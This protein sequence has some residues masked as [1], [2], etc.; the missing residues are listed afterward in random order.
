MKVN[1]SKTHKVTISFSKSIDFPPVTANG[2]PIE[3]VQCAKLVGVYI[4]SILNGTHISIAYSKKPNRDSFFYPNYGEHVLHQRICL[5]STSALSGQ[6]WSMPHPHG[7]HR[8]RNTYHTNS[9]PYR[10]EP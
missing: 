6:P 2:K 4:Q 9:K 8:F 5:K 1:T 3:K 7:V 10:K